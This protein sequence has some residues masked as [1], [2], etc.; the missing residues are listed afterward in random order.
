MKDI[1]I[2]IGMSVKRL[3]AGMFT[4]GAI[5]ASALLIVGTSVSVQGIVGAFVFGFALAVDSL[6][7]EKD[8]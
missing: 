7:T 2:H 1:K 8:G 6:S 3:L 5:Y 4:A